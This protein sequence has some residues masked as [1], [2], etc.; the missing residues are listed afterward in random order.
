MIYFIIGFIIGCIV[1]YSYEYWRNLREFNK[2]QE[3]YKRML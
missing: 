1:M 2:R 3:R